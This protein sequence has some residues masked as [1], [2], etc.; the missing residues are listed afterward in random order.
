MPKKVRAF[1]LRCA[2][3]S[4]FAKHQ[5]Y[6]ID[7]SHIDEPKTKHVVEFLKNFKL[8]K[9]SVL[10]VDGGVVDT[11]F[12]LASNN[13][14]N[15]TVLPQHRINVYDILKHKKLVLC[16]DVIPYLVKRLEN[17]LEDPYEKER[18]SN[19]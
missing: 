6:I 7:S 15:L 17:P 9:E 3:A 11:N 2:L 4:K 12:A 19:I 13:V 1:G 5:L 16:K 18:Q 14:N 8:D 10:F